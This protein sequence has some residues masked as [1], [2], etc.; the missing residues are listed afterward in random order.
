[1]NKIKSF[2][3]KII[4]EAHIAPIA[5][6]L[7]LIPLYWAPN[8]ISS[9]TQG[10]ELLFK[11]ITIFTL[12]MILI[13][14]LGKS[15]FK[16]KKIST[17]NI[18]LLLVLQ[19]FI[20]A[21]TNILSSTPIVT[22]YGSYSRGFGFLDE[23]FLFLFTIYCALQLSEE[24]IL[25]LLKL[26]FIS[27]L[28]IGVYSII[29]KTG[30]DPFFKNY[31]INIFD[32]R[33]FSFLGNPSYLGQFMLLQLL[34]G[35][36][37]LFTANNRKEKL[38]YV[39][40]SAI[41]LFTILLSGTRTALLSL[42]IIGV[43]TIIKYRKDILKK[44]LNN[45]KKTL[46]IIIAILISSFVLL[47]KDRFSLSSLSLR[48]MQSR[49]EIWKGTLNLIE[50]HPWK[51]Y[52]SETFYIYFPEIVTKKFLT[53]EEN[54]NISA[55]RIHNE[56]LEIFFSH[57]IFSLIIY[58]LILLMLLKEF[59]KTKNS[60]ITALTAILLSNIFQNQFSF[61]DTT[62]SVLVAFCF[63]SLINITS[64]ETFTIQV[65]FI[66]RL[67]ITLL[68]V[69]F[70]CFL[71]F[72]TVYKPIKSQLAYANSKINSTLSY[73]KAVN[74]LKEALTYTPYYSQLWYELM[75]IDPSSMERALYY[76]EKI[77][78]NSGNV[79]AWKGNLYAKSDPAKASEYYA[80]AL[81][82]NPQHPN[83]IR[84]FA[85]MLYDKGDYESALFLYDQFLEAVPD[86]WQWRDELD[87]HTA[88]ER[89]SYDAFF[90][91]TPYFWGVIE[92]M[93]K[94]LIILK[95]EKAT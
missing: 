11:S 26:T 88:I 67:I 27:G 83:W 32:G 56:T 69:P 23:M 18:F 4:K 46:I 14:S 48:S 64:K 94:I 2:V 73:E 19:I 71:G 80:M 13:V 16:F 7:F 29:Q 91:Q 86:Y 42:I 72:L 79:L 65:K 41:S 44:F 53:L 62:I 21:V 1:M 57:G 47:P 31:D 74:N 58:L 85:D 38:F 81:E 34:V 78:G 22:I 51:G 45:K 92:K 75:F 50:K 89:K 76:L 36:Y 15:N 54:I 52:G 37:L 95:E 55:D 5:L 90:K 39:V 87:M 40:G 93:N 35:C 33:V 8:F 10:K 66:Q 12:L 9:F 77:D 61:P 63:G 28:I 68:F 30:T 82:K 84:A 60:M 17:S 24:K 3:K 25:K 43:L 49:I 70:V 20:F 59:F 6:S